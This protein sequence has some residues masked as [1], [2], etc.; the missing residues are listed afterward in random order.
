MQEK[1]GESKGKGLWLDSPSLFSPPPSPP[2]FLNSVLLSVVLR[3]AAS[4]TTRSWSEIQNL[5]PCPEL[6][7]QHVNVNIPSGVCMHLT[8]EMQC[9][10]A[11]VLVFLGS[12]GFPSE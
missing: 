1:V 2:P 7:H 10:E 5:E 4:I 11:S 12:L 6:E 9:K 8:C 3:P